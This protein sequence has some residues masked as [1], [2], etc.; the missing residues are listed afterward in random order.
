MGQRSVDVF[1]SYVSEISVVNSPQIVNEREPH[2]PFM[3]LIQTMLVHLDVEAPSPRG[4]RLTGIER[5]GLRRVEDSADVMHEAAEVE[6][7]ESAAGR[8]E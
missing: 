1:L 8:Q 4:P 6:A 2:H 7:D 5:K 3:D